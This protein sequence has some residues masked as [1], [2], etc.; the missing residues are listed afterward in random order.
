[1]KKLKFT[2]ILVVVAAVAIG[3]PGCNK[4]AADKT[5]N[6]ADSVVTQQVRAQQASA[7]EVEQ[8]ASFTATVLP[9]A[10]NSIAPQTPGRIRKI[11][12]EVG[13]RVAKGQKLVQMDAVQQS[14]LKTQV[15]NL[16]ETYNR[17]EQLYNVGGA[18]K[19]DLDNAKT[20]LEVAQTNLNNAQENTY[21]LSP[22][23]GVVTARNYDDGDL[24]NGQAPVLTVMQINPVK[25][26]V[27][28]SEAYFP[29]IKLGMTADVTFDA[30]EGENF[31]GK[32]GLIY[33]TV[34]P[35]TR[36]FAADVK[37]PNVN[38]KI[39]PGMYGR[40]NINFGKENRI[41]ISDKS[42][43]KQ[44]GTNDRYVYIVNNDN[45]VSY[46]K[47]E[48][49]TRIGNEYVILSGIEEG[50]KVVVDGLAGLIDGEKVS[51]VEN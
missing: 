38:G 7:R 25:L 27:N 40:L 35:L 36:T 30:L 11:F 1:M 45:S 6:A 39:R 13:N 48:L 50:D 17:I 24:F 21:L 15:D 51:V 19:Q 20:Q 43:V 44:Q 34:D 2:G 8:T 23:T 49:G 18:S 4:K 41:V 5:L 33:P 14:V 10:K 26:T 32:I 29:K 37:L 47:V 22:L 28:I 9:E 3:M 31:T 16:Q 42:V 46:K 12:V